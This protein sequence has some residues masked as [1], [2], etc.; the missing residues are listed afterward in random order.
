M[1]SSLKPRAE[2]NYLESN[3]SYA[4]DG[5]RVGV[6][7]T[8]ASDAARTTQL[9]EALACTILK[10]RDFENDD[11]GGA[12]AHEAHVQGAVRL[13]IRIL[14]SHIGEPLM[15]GDEGS[16]SQVIRT[17]LV[18]VLLLQ[19]ESAVFSNGPKRWNISPM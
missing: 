3:G 8:A 9:V 6:A 2:G 16:I 4:R 10:R 12:G 17:R 5:A 1:A 7:R 18:K 19:L 14:T 11:T 15:L 13:C